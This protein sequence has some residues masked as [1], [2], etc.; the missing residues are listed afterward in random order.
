MLSEHA[1]TSIFKVPIQDGTLEITTE[2][3]KIYDSKDL[4]SSIDLQYVKAITPV[5]EN[6]IRIHYIGEIES[7]SIGC[8]ILDYTLDKPKLSAV[9]TC[10][11][12]SKK[13]T[14]IKQNTPNDIGWVYLKD[15]EILN[16]YDNVCINGD[17]GI[18]YI[19]DMRI[20]YETE[21]EIPI[22]VSFEQVISIKEHKDCAITIQCDYPLPTLDSGVPPFFNIILPKDIDRDI[23][24]TVIKEAFLTFNLDVPTNLSKLTKHYSKMNYN[25][26]Y[27]LAGDMDKVFY[28]YLK[29]MAI[30]IFGQSTESYLT[31]DLKLVLACML[32]NW[33]INLISSISDEEL[34]QR[35]YAKRYEK[36][37]DFH[38]YEREDYEEYIDQDKKVQTSDHKNLTSY[39][40]HLKNV[41]SKVS[42]DCDM[43]MSTPSL[44]NKIN[45]DVFREYNKRVMILYREW[46]KS[47]PLED[48]TDEYSDE[49]ITYL[50]KRLDTE[51]GRTSMIEK[52]MNHKELEEHLAT[53]NKNKRT[54]AK[55][56]APDH[57]KSKYIYNNCWYDKRRRTWYVEDD[58]LT[59]FLVFVADY[60]PDESEKMIGRRVWGFKKENVDMFCGFPSIEATRSGGDVD[61]VIGYNRHTGQIR[62]GTLYATANHILPILRETDIVP[63]LVKKYG[64][65]LASYEEISYTVYGSGN[66]ASFTP[67]MRMCFEEIYDL[68][69]IP[70][71]ERVRRAVFCVETGLS[72]SPDVPL[73][74]DF[75]KPLDIYPDSMYDERLE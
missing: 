42:A 49:W 40:N 19:T 48:F 35:I 24:C 17:H 38:H 26:L 20:I 34:N 72:H 47:V 23:V 56:L 1:E 41:L 67:K 18:L 8:H 57:I 61:G 64:K 62:R 50:L 29:S 68:A 30:I 46:C 37:E 11:D 58:N 36:L 66:V 2:K 74:E 51:Q 55:F 44:K 6:G 10:R 60:T 21:L 73:G 14:E 45:A 27:R 71:N 69:K 39:S 4:L 5:K 7:D 65:M 28:E 59:E 75:A 22:D 31:L 13:I 9:E 32:H 43:I 15:D 12:I 52:L 33:D 63:E 3:I 53:R 25:E 54:L 16:T 70:L